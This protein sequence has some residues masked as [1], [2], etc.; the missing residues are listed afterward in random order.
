LQSVATDRLKVRGEDQLFSYKGS[1][2][3][4]R[5]AVISGA[6]GYCDSNTVPAGEVWC[7][8]RV[9]AKDNTTAT[10]AHAIYTALGG[11][12]TT[13]DDRVAALALNVWSHGDCE[14]YLDAGDAAR[15]AFTG[16]LA[17]DT[18][19]VTLHGHIMTLE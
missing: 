11:T 9:S 5:T 15:V 3:N 12:S 6:G 13:T 19:R 16:G 2:E 14:M 10:T 17:G 4:T 7:V 18:C 8:R 1:L